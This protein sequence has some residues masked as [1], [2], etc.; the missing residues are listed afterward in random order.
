MKMLTYSE[1]VFN[2]FRVVSLDATID[3]FQHLELS[4]LVRC[5]QVL[6]ANLRLLAWNVVEWRKKIE[7]TFSKPNNH[8]RLTSIQL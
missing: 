1:K 7:H 4:G 6:K 2:I 3:T 8:K 5:L